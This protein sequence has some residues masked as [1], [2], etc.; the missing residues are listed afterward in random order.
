MFPASLEWALSFSSD[1]L[2]DV[3]GTVAQPRSTGF[4]ACQKPHRLLPRNVDFAQVEH[5]GL[6]VVLGGE[7][8]A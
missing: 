6:C 5:Q 3:V 2:A 7:G 4:A 8:F 1:P